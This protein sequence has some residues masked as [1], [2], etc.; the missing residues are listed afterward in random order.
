MVLNILQH[1]AP[2]ESEFAVETTPDLIQHFY[3]IESDGQRGYLLKVTK[4]VSEFKTGF[5]AFFRL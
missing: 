4:L 1:T 3:F 5:S 2:S